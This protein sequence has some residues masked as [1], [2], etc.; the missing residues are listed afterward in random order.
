MAQLMEICKFFFVDK[1]LDPVIQLDLMA[2]VTLRDFLLVLAVADAGR[3]ARSAAHIALAK[4]ARQTEEALSVLSEHICRT[5]LCRPE[6]P[7]HPTT[8]KVLAGRV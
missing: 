4:A 6:K 8:K 1:T 3:N 2:E 5:N 7:R